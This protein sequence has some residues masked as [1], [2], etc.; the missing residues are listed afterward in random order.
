MCQKHGKSVNFWAESAITANFI[1]ITGIPPPK[2]YFSV[3]SQR[4]GRVGLGE[5]AVEYYP[6]LVTMMKCLFGSVT[7]RQAW[8]PI[9]VPG[10]EQIPFFQA[11]SDGD[12]SP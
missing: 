11:K 6:S 9:A 7:N 4:S 12:E 5:C 8:S 1:M 3:N 2:A 10:I